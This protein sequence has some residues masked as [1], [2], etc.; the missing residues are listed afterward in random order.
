MP[1][2]EHIADHIKFHATRLLP[3]KQKALAARA[4]SAIIDSFE[5][6]P[7]ECRA[8]VAFEPKKPLTACDIIVAP[9]K[10]GEV[11]LEGTEDSGD[12]TPTSQAGGGDDALDDD[13]ENIIVMNRTDHGFN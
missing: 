2:A 1:G 5:G 12:E 8:M 6:K 10:A 13:D 11:R 4:N 7:I 9:P 3:L